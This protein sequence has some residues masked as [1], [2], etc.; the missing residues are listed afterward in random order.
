MSLPV[1]VMLVGVS[2]TTEGDCPLATGA[3]FTA[4][5]VMVIVAIFESSEPSFVRK[6]KLSPPA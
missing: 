2:S 5:T 6:V 4:L 3:S 1:K